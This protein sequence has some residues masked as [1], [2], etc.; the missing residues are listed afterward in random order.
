MECLPG[1][2]NGPLPRHQ[3]MAA[4]FSSPWPCLHAEETLDGCLRLSSM[5]LQRHNGTQ[6]KMQ[7]IS[8]QPT[9][10]R[11]K[12]IGGRSIEGVEFRLLQMNPDHRGVFTEVYSQDWGSQILPKQWSV[13]QSK[14]GVF[15]GMHL[16]FR[17]EES[18]VLI[19]GH[20]YVGLLDIR[21]RS[22][23]NGA[24][25]LYELD[26][27]QLACLIFPRG[28]LHGWYLCED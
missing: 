11:S 7:L 4:S 17:H 18:F 10:A 21:P 15:R 2:I 26:A 1:L 9:D 24:W 20:A 25:C 6:R 19:S 28:V 16:H 23:T 12:Q 14:A 27:A 13:V 22:R 8:G 3:T 5:S